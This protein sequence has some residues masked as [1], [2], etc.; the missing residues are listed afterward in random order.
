M[1][2]GRGYFHVKDEEL[3]LK[4]AFISWALL[5]GKWGEEI[6]ERE[7][8]DN[9]Y[10]VTITKELPREEKELLLRIAEGM[11]SVLAIKQEYVASIKTSC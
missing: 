8:G 10:F 9:D 6:Y 5:L 2:Q 4:R 7:E 3:R 1:G 11:Q